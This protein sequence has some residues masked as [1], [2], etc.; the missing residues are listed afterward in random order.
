[1]FLK[2]NTNLSVS[3]PL[4]KTGWSNSIY[5]KWKC[6]APM[7][8]L[9][10]FSRHLNTVHMVYCEMKSRK[11]QQLEGRVYIICLYSYLAQNFV[12]FL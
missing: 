3:G 8:Q 10:I 12:K 11:W 6:Y 7:R 4:G 2:I 1:M 9:F 5:L